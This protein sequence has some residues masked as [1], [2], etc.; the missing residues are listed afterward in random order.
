M[1]TAAMLAVSDETI[2][3]MKVAGC[4][5]TAPLGDGSKEK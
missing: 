4:L 1:E 2:H 5:A 3:K